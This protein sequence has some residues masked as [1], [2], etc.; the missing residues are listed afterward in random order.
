MAT[1]VLGVWT[2]RYYVR[3]SELAAGL[4]VRIALRPEEGVALAEYRLPGNGG[5]SREEL[6]ADEGL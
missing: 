1:L 5:A 2:R 6:G 4:E 3:K